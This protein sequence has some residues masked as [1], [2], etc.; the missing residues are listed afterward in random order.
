MYLGGDNIIDNVKT[1]SRI[2]IDGSNTA[3]GGYVGVVEQGSLILRHLEEEDLEGFRCGIWNTGN[4]GTMMEF[5]GSFSPSVY[6][7]VSGAVGKVENGFVVYE[8]SDGN[9][10]ILLC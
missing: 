7:Y 9:N 2:A 3:V 8:G 10:E 6:P 5:G 1:G 4:N